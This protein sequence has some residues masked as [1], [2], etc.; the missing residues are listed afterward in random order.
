MPLGWGI[1]GAGQ[2]AKDFAASMYAVDGSELVAVGA[3]RAS[4]GLALFA[5]SFGCTAHE[6]YEALVADAAVAAVYVA[7]IHPT[8]YA[9]AKLAL[10]SGKHVLVEKPFAMNGRE[11]AELAELAKA[12][13]LFLMEAMWTACLPAT[14]EALRLV[15]AGEIGDVLSASASVGGVWY[16]QE[17]L[18]EQESR[19][20]AKVLG[21]GVLL[22][23]GCYAIAVST[24]QL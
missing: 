17:A 23:V 13:G 19:D 24:S 21:S 12:R 16:T 8:H 3:R 9:L 20:R 2:I 10:E 7:T 18:A 11:A 22:D 14:I 1:L 4:A 6:S 5:E 15:A